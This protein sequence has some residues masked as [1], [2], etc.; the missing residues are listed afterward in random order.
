MFNEHCSYLKVEEGEGGKV[1]EAGRQDEGTQTL[2]LE[3]L[4]LIRHGKE[5][6]SFER[7]EG[8]H[9]AAGELKSVQVVD[10]FHQQLDRQGQRAA[11][12]T[13]LL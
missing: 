10:S 7:C 11:R 3:P 13:D 6:S 8:Q 12:K 4:Q 2:P 1:R 5:R 9:L